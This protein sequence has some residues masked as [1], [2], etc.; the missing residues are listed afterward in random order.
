MACLSITTSDEC[1]APTL[2]HMTMPF[3]YKCSLACSLLLAACC[4]IWGCPSAASAPID[5][6]GGGPA[7]AN[8]SN[9]LFV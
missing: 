6:H 1:K 9:R 8:A 5:E 7:D 4:M 2:R 3:Y